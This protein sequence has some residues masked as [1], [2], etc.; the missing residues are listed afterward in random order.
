[1]SEC[2]LPEFG[3]KGLGEGVWAG[4]MPSVVAGGVLECHV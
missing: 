2:G 1:M 4:F 3:G